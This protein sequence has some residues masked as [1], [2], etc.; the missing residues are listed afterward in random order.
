MVT[1]RTQPPL[2]S[3][4]PVVLGFL[5]PTALLAGLLIQLG[6]VREHTRLSHLGLGVKS[7]L[8]P[9]EH[10]LDARPFAL[11]AVVAV[12]V[13]ALGEVVQRSLLG[14][15]AR[16]RWRVLGAAVVAAV[17]GCALVGETGL[18][19]VLGAESFA[20]S[21]FASPWELLRIAAGL[22]LVWTAWRWHRHGRPPRDRTARFTP[23]LVLGALTFLCLVGA[24]ERH[25]ANLGR[26]EALRFHTVP[27][28][29]LYTA[30][31]LA[32]DPRIHRD[33]CVQD[34]G[35]KDSAYRFRYWGFRL[36]HRAGDD[37]YLWTTRPLPTGGRQGS[38]T[39]VR[40]DSS[41]RLEFMY[42][43][44]PDGTCPSGSERL[45]APG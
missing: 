16:V 10:M 11:L 27:P 33:V 42:E 32:V 7:N 17:V 14:R 45:A 5:P 21:P 25:A 31:R 22:L 28:V 43:R 13:L 4:L 37:L 6:W 12:G 9:F 26:E 38:V 40:L 15:L 39:V 8:S 19:A 29:T 24:A 2:W 41:N 34:T 30:S 44:I 18:Q 1:R 36:A 35:V 23:D 20:G 3:A